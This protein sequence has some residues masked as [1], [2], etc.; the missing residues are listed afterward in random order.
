MVERGEEEEE[1]EK[2]GEV[3]ENMSSIWNMVF[4]D[5]PASPHIRTFILFFICLNLTRYFLLLRLLRSFSR[6][7]LLVFL[8]LSLVSNM[9]FGFLKKY[10]FSFSSAAGGGQGGGGRGGGGGAGGS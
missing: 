1:G 2:E 8:H 7:D 4:D 6:S 10:T 9:N 3:D 5:S